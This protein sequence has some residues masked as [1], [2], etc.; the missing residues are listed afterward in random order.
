M[1]RLLLA[2][3]GLAVASAAAAPAWAELEPED[4]VIDSAQ[5]LVD[6][7]SVPAGNE[8]HLQAIHM[9]HGFATGVTQYALLWSQENGAA[10]FCVPEPRPTRNEVIAD[11]ISWMGA[12]PQ[13]LGDPAPEAVVRFLVE[14]FPCR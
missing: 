11:W 6:L 3:F 9:C 14:S 1:R 8:L 7:C 13:Y 12:H 10:L 5:D 2:G 4:F